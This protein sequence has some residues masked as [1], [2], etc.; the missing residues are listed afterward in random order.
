MEIQR[1]LVVDEKDNDIWLIHPTPGFCIKFRDTEYPKTSVSPSASDKFFINLTHCIEIPPPKECVNEDSVAKLIEN[2][3]EAFK[4]PVCVGD[5]DMAEDR[6]MILVTKVDALINSNFFH[7][8]VSESEFFKQLTI[9]AIS[10]IIK[11]KYS[12]HLNLSKQIVLRNKKF[13]GD[14][15]IQRVRKRPLNSII[16]LENDKISIQKLEQRQI[17]ID[18]IE[19]TEQKTPRNFKVQIL[20]GQFIDI[21]IKVRDYEKQLVYDKSRINLKLNG[22]RIVVILDSHYAIN[23]FFLPVRIT[24]ENICEC[25]F[26][27]KSSIVHIKCQINWR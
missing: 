7:K 22:D 19:E 18:D 23:D 24:K 3:P 21:K 6:N 26:D 13:L 5:L 1:P 20:K 10:D 15:K 12:I 8:F 27:S 16:D 17:D 2:D 25:F 9:R 11:A 4:I 14:L